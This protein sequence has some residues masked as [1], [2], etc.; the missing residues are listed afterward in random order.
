M[1]QPVI[2]FIIVLSIGVLLA[3]AAVG[4]TAY[5]RAQVETNPSQT[6]A[7]SFPD[8]FLD[9][10]PP[11]WSIF[12]RFI[13]LILAGFAFLAAVILLIIGYGW[14]NLCRERS[15]D[16]LI[17]LGTFVL[18]QLAAFSVTALGW[19]PLDYQFTWPG[20]NLSALWAEAPVRTVTVFFVLAFVSVVI[21]F[22]L[23]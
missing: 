19:N 23:E 14:K 7:P 4:I 2:F 21:G 15:F 11:C 20:W 17:L 22:A 16:M 3:V 12:C 13:V 18:P 9:C 5:G 1:E 8:R 6:S 10:L